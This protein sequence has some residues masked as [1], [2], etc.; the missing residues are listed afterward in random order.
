MSSRRLDQDQHIGLDQTSLRR[1]QDVFKTCSRLLLD[2]FKT[3]SRR[4]GKMFSRRLQD[5]LS[6]QTF[7]VKLCCCCN[8]NVSETYCEDGYLQEDL[9]RSHFW[10]IYGECTKFAR[11]IKVSQVL[12]FHFTTPFSGCLQTRI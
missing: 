10:E 8:R 2:V 1:L 12:V 4:L 6:S 7:L 11:V 5:V 3:S 9:S